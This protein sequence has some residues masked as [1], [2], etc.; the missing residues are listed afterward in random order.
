MLISLVDDDIKNLDLE[1][2]E[3]ERLD[4]N[5]AC[6]QSFHPCKISI[7]V[8]KNA[9]FNG[10]F[11][12]LCNWSGKLI[13]DIY[14][15]EGA[16]A[17]WRSASIASREDRKVFEA[18]IYHLSPR[19]KG[20]M[21]NYGITRDSSRLTFSGTSEI[22][23]YAIGSSTRQEAKI[24]IFDPQ[25]DGACSPRL[26]IDENDVTASHSASCGKLSEEHI[27]YLLSR[28]L[29]L[30]EARRLLTLGYLKPVVSYFVDEQLRQRVDLAIEE[31]I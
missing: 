27:F 19:S 31:G 9:I 16:N 23:K 20:L 29:S 25:S 17:V 4:L 7:K 21:S 15:E 3:G 12:D 1:V 22:K 10:A 13:L 6:F 11:A 2:K 18:S 24:I 30:P 26:N 28:G 14:L 8:C 5:L